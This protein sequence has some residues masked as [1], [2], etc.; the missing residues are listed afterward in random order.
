MHT[1]SNKLNFEGQKVFV[2]I[3]VHLK[4]WNVSIFTEHF[5]HKTFN[6]P[7]EAEA[8]KEYLSHNFPNA[9]YYSAYEAGFSGLWAHYRL[10]DLGIHN[11]VINP[12]DV[13]TTH[14]EKLHKRDAVDSRK[15][16]RSLRSNELKGIY[17]HSV[18]ALQDRSLIRVRSS[19]VKDLSRNKQRIK[20]ML[21]FY[22]K[23]IPKEFENC[24]GHWSKRFIL[25]LKSVEFKNETGRQALHFYILQAEQL[26][27]NL[28][29][30]NRAVRALS[31]TDRYCENYRLITSVPGIGITVGMTLLTE[32]EDIARFPDSDHLAGFIGFVPTCHSSTAGRDNATQTQS[33]A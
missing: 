9:E 20:S 22:G 16:A 26:R 28:L 29:D 1:Q 11:I 25:W 31:K 18:N 19:L 32:I 10:M 21:H 6:A 23:R 2:G 3:D 8:L 4:S 30:A 13:P 5:H 33:A 24:G 15:I 12:S 7:P 17:T 27:S 14:K